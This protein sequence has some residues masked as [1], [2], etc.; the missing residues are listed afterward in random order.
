VNTESQSELI[1]ISP[2][3]V[4]RHK[5]LQLGMSLEHAALGSKIRLDHLSA[6]ESAETQHIPQVYLNG[7]IRTYARF[8]GLPAGTIDKHL[9]YARGSEPLVQSVF[10]AAIPKNPDDRWFKATSYV[11]ASVV[12]I[13]LVWQFTAE[14]VRFSQ[15]DPVNRVSD[16]EARSDGATIPGTDSAVSSKS[17][18]PNTSHLQA[19]IAPLEDVRRNRPAISGSGAESAWS[20]ISQV[21]ATDEPAQ[22]LTEGEQSFS[23]TASADTWVEIV[24]GKGN[25]IEMDLL[26][27]GNGRSY[28]AIAPVKLLLGRA[29]AIELTHNGEVVELAPYTRGNVA[30]ITLSDEEQ[31]APQAEIQAKA[32]V[33]AK[34]ET[35][36][37]S[38]QTEPE[39]SEDQ[40]TE[41]PAQPDIQ[42]NADA[43]TSADRQS[44]ADGQNSANNGLN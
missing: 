38:E 26:R 37:E 8:L 21:A 39:S 29:S 27:A 1:P 18:S 35:G 14:A 12:V 44:D 33:E 10:S 9:P 41:D 24:D 28:V 20:A 23:I 6:I 7:H 30:R 3:D 13:A 15:G 32:E 36:A 42:S 22:I 16:S 40:S 25:K 17:P 34:V 43:Q 5:R 31:V 4:L 11:L 19:S 2:G